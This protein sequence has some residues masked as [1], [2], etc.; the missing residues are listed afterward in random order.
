MSDDKLRTPLARVRGLG[1]AKS[2]TEHFW[3][4]RLTGV[5]ALLLSSSPWCSCVKLRGRNYASGDGYA[6]QR[7]SSPC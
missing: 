2:G 6:R 7:R 4:Q 5:A 3:M 1:S